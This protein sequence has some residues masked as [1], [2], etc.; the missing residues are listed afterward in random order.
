MGVKSCSICHEKAAEK[1]IFHTR[2]SVSLSAI[3]RLETF[4]SHI[5]D[6]DGKRDNMSKG[7]F[8]ESLPGTVRDYPRYLTKVLCEGKSFSA[9]RHLVQTVKEVEEV[10]PDLVPPMTRAVM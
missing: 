10:C 7:D 6:E 4:I 5:K 1:G 2:G 3:F 9:L 8:C